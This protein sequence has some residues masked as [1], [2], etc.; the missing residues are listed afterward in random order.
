M[1]CLNSQ[2]HFVHISFFTYMIKWKKIFF[3][4]SSVQPTCF[5]GC[6]SCLLLTN[7]PSFS[8]DHCKAG[9]LSH[10]WLQFNALLRNPWALLALCYPFAQLWIFHLKVVSFNNVIE[11]PL[12]IC[13]YW[14]FIIFKDKQR[15]LDNI[16]DKI[17][18]E[19]TQMKKTSHTEY[20]KT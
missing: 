20:I 2:L 4:L 10:N 6:C 14:E 5:S 12:H 3:L 19:Y 9:S 18:Y 13:I 7:L 8:L 11:V 1:C 16:C 17:I 15:S